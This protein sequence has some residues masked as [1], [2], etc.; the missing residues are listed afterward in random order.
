MLCAICQSIYHWANDCPNKVKEEQS[1][2]VKITLFTQDIHKCYIEKFAGET[3]NCAVL[4]SQCTKDVCGKTWL[5]S[6]LNTLT[7]K[8][9]QN[10]LEESSSSSFRFVDENCKTANKSVT[11]PARIGNQDVMIKID[12]IDSYL[13][14][15]LSKESMKK[16]D[17]KID[18]ARD[19]VSFLNQNVDIVFTSSS[20]YAIPISRTEQLLDHYDKNNE[21]ERVLLTIN[22]LSS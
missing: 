9:A 1:S 17:L 2:H 5:D 22:E 3:L 4:D 16:G 7:E 14:F 13:P 6:Y 15:L 21:S 8:D 19:K 18:F 20:H 10:V 11:I 12:V